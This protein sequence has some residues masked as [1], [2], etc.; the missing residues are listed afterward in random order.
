MAS[1]R[2]PETTVPR[3]FATRPSVASLLAGCK[4]QCLD[5]AGVARPDP[6]RGPYARRVRWPI[7]FTGI[8]PAYS[9]SGTTNPSAASNLPTIT[10]PVLPQAAE[11]SIPIRRISDGAKVEG[12]VIAQNVTVCGR[13]KG[14][15][16]ELFQYWGRK[17]IEGVDDSMPVSCFAAQTISRCRLRPLRP[18]RRRRRRPTARTAAT[19]SILWP[20]M[21]SKKRSPAATRCGGHSEER[22][23]RERASSSLARFAL[24][25]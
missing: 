8:R 15:I 11:S 2:K 19:A 13:V 1:Q 6:F 4:I 21:Y 9:T 23:C 3:S 10:R 18:H 24:Q 12:S 17:Y 7:L 5:W 16:R 20:T 25:I 14:T 22:L